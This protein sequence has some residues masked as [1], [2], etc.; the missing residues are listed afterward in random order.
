[1][2]NVITTAL[3]RVQPN[4]RGEYASA[5]IYNKLD[6]VSYQGSSYICKTDNVVGAVPTNATYWQLVA[7][8]G[9]QG[10]RGYTGSF[11]TPSA[12]A[13]VLPT[14]SDPTVQINA[15]G[16]DD[17]K[18]FSFNFGIPAGP[19]GF[20]QV[21]A[22]ASAI[23]AGASPIASASLVGDG[24]KTL[25]FHFGIPAADGEGVKKV[26]DI[27]PA[28]GGNVPLG[29]VR[30]SDVQDLSDLQKLQA[31]ENINAQAAGSYIAEPSSK[32]YGNFLQYGGNVG[33]PSWISASIQEVPLGGT[34][35]YILRKQANGYGWT[36]VHETPAG[37]STGDVLTKNSNADYDF[38]WNSPI[39]TSEIDTMMNE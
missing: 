18:I 37:G 30:Y 3:G 31:R 6:Y 36:P 29:A 1:M 2:S 19:L 14:G 8:K 13:S 5:T 25:S 21:A 10:V 28:T 32:I 17:A 39:T 12:A 11:G 35:G 27:G 23:S 20:T 24:D 22:D 16:P 15:T 9:D 4:Y 7:N 38:K 34:T 33:A 26:D